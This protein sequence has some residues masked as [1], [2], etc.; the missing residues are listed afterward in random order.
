MPVPSSPQVPI[1]APSPTLTNPDMILP[2]DSSSEES[3][4]SATRKPRRALF[5]P[6]IENGHSRSGSAP[7][8]RIRAKATMYSPFHKGVLRRHDGSTR[9]RSSSEKGDRGSSPASYINRRKV[10]HWH[11]LQLFKSSTMPLSRKVMQR[12]PAR[13]MT[14]SRPGTVSTIHQ[15]SWRK[16]RTIHTHMLP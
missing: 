4:P 9:L 12:L 1:G 11:R 16:T 7:D 2:H 13:I 15:Q 14:K 6:A 3:T 10:L 5:P 8:D